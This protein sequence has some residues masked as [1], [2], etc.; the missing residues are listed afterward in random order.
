MNLKEIIISFL[1]KVTVLHTL[2]KFFKSLFFRCTEIF[3]DAVITH[4]H[5]HMKFPS[6]QKVL[7]DG[8]GQELIILGTGW[9]YME[10]SLSCSLC[11]YIFKLS[12]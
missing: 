11:F 2:V 10:E 5:T 7:S 8:A 1:D 9:W 6:L 12:P 4:T 3:M